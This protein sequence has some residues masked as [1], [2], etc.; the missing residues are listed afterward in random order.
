MM[1]RNKPVLKYDV[2]VVCM[3]SHSDTYVNVSVDFNKNE[4]IFFVLQSNEKIVA[5][6]VCNVVRIVYGNHKK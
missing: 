3:D 4:T 5:Y 6:P 2:T 1:E